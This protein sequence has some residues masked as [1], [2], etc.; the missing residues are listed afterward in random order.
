MKLIHKATGSQIRTGGHVMH[1]GERCYVLEK[2]PSPMGLHLERPSGMTFN[3]VDPCDVEC[4]YID[5]K[6]REFD[7]YQ[8]AIHG[9]VLPKDGDMVRWINP[10]D[11]TN[12]VT[13]KVAQS[14]VKFG[15]KVCLWIGDWH[16]D[17]SLAD[18][19]VL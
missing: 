1:H 6:G 3:C 11:A 16:A 14:W 2:G 18:V 5:R 10:K 19:T 12:V 4:V 7:T 9:I 15:G 17:I 13:G 8:A